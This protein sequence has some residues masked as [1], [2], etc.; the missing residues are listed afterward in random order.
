[1]GIFHLGYSG[2]KTFVIV[3]LKKGVFTVPDQ[4][5]EA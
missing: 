3:F 5:K 4:S 2:F 1:M